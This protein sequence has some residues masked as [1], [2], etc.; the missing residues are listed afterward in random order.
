MATTRLKQRELAAFS[1]ALMM[2][3]AD[4]SAATLTERILATLHRLFDCDFT[5]FSLIDLRRAHFHASALSPLVPDWPGTEA[6]QRHLRSDP[7]AAH[8]MRT[9]EPYAVKISDFVSLR[10]YRNTSVYTEVFGRV[11]CDR[12]LGFA[13]QKDGAPVSLITTVNRKGRD[14]SD[15]DRRLLDLLRPHLL[16]ANA[17]AHADQRLQAG[18]ERERARWGD[19]FGAG[20]GELDPAGRPL[21]LTP[22][23]EAL[24]GKFFPGHAGQCTPRRLPGALERRLA[25]TLRR[26]LTPDPDDPTGPR[27]LVWRFPGPDDRALRVRLVASACPPCWQ[28][29]LE[30][31]TSVAPARLLSRSLKIT[32]REAEV[33]YWLKQGKTN[34]EI[35]V[36]I[37]AATK[38]VGKHVENI[39]L[40][41]K[42]ENRTAAA[43]MAAEA[44][45]DF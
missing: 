18:R 16:Q 11:G 24:L 20:L 39:F 22:R 15:G 21:W 23:A 7:A 8:I 5:S 25:P 45:T 36:I 17:N 3:Y 13:D 42:V 28:I 38:T 9:R 32:T 14:F 34:A 41:L 26:G 29:L 43:S 30:D 10:E 37:T 4:V 27:R 6:H 19:L 1:Q 33:L 35:G 31:A 2:L 12:R 44:S 40:K